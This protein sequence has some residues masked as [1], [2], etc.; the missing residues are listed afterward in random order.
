MLCE[1]LGLVRFQQNHIAA[2]FALQLCRSAQRDYAAVGVNRQAIAALG[3]FHQVRG[4]QN[5]HALFVTQNLQILPKV[6]ACAGIEAGCR[7]VEQEHGRMMQQP[8]C[9]FETTL[10]AA[11]ESLGFFLSAI[12]EAYA[13]QHLGNALLQRCAA[14]SV[15]VSDQHQVLLRRELDVDALGLEDHADVA[16]NQRRLARDIVSHD[17]GATARRQHQSRENAEGCG[18][19]AAVGAEQTEN[20][21][22]ANIERHTGQRDAIAVLMAKS[23]QLNDGSLQQKRSCRSRAG[24]E[25]RKRSCEGQD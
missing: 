18:L 10:H 23:L 5:G 13:A 22:G 6:A 21:R 11:G 19:A 8:F 2:D 3:F 12:G 7:L 9:E 1:R 17:Q 20:L 16:P 25:C 4:H 15:N 14:K 24:E